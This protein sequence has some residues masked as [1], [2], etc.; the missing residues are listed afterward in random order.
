MKRL[1]VFLYTQILGKKIYDEFKDDLGELKDVYVTTED[2]YPRI[3]G[4][5]VKKAGVTFHY[6]FKNINFYDQD[7][8]VVIKTI[9]SR[10][11]LPRTYSY[12]L[13]QHLLDRKIVDINGKKVVRVDDLR[14]AEIVGE[15]RVVAV[16]TGAPAR[17][18]RAGMPKLGKYIY[19]ILGKDFEDKVL[20]WD[21][22][23]SV[24]MVNN[25]LQLSVPYQ[26]LST[27]HPADLADILE[28]LDDMSRKRVF[29][30]LDEDL[31]ADTFEEIED[32]YKGSIIKDLS[33]TK[34]AELLE[35]MDNDEIVD[36]LDELQG[37]E[38]EK[39]LFNLE[40][41]DA[42]EVKELLKYENESVGS[43]MSK[44]FIAFRLS[45]TVEETIDILKEM[46]PDEDVMFY[47]YVTDEEGRIEGLVILRDLLL[48]D[49]STMLKEIME[50]NITRVRHDDPI[51]EAIEQASKYDLLSTAVV[52]EDGR[53]VGIV[54]IHD[55]IDEVLYP[56][57]KK[58]NRTR[59]Q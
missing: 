26:K 57:W 50:G 40:K 25:N 58:K 48:S 1:L 59:N 44:D 9:G 17:F 7:G 30:A 5:K 43:M 53:L 16:E 23:E 41:E 24:E 47:I 12:L 36:L 39:V 14:I 33:E 52:D 2:G 35:N 42:E 28:E 3:I 45:V 10:E 49:G 8:Q 15:Y 20:M 19:K 21:N 51:A 22:V 6:E 11:I 46:Q 34:T 38:R 56:L 55:I 29:E 13:S 18:R 27:L 31:A 54:K 4:Y 32:E 37:E